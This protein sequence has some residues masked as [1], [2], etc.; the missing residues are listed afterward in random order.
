MLFMLFF[1]TD[2]FGDPAKKS[3]AFTGQAHK[4]Y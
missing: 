4:E 1:V 3:V 2:A